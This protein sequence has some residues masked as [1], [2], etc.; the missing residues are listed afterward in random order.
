MNAIRSADSPIVRP[1][2]VS[3]IPGATGAGSASR[4][5]ANLPAFWGS[6]FACDAR[7]SARASFG[8][9]VIGTFES[10]SAPPASAAV[11]VPTA[12]WSAAVVIATQA[13][14]QAMPTVAAWI[15]GGRPRARL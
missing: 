1:V 9:Y 10:D 15:D 14:A 13:D 8:V 6:V 11:A 4:I 3:L 5:S 2:D 12:M 7:T